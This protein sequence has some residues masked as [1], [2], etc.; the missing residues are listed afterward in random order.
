LY[1]AGVEAV[2]E[3]EIQP[4]LMAEVAEAVALTAALQ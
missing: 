2:P 3:E 4:M 1:N